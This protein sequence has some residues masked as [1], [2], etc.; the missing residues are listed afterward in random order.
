MTAILRN[1]AAVLPTGVGQAQLRGGGGGA[2]AARVRVG[3][4]GQKFRKPADPAAELLPAAEFL[5]HE[6]DFEAI[7]ESF[8]DSPFDP[9]RR[10]VLGR[11][12]GMFAMDY[13]GARPEERRFL[14]RLLAARNAR[15]G[16]VANR[17]LHLISTSPVVRRILSLGVAEARRR[18]GPLAGFL[19]A[20]Q[21]RH[22]AATLRLLGPETRELV[23]N[24]LTL[25]GGEAAKPTGA[26]RTLERALI[27]KA[28][29]ARRHALG[30]WSREGQRAVNDVVAFAAEI[31]GCS[32]PHLARTTTVFAD[33]IVGKIARSPTP[34][35]VARGELDPIFA[36]QL[37]GKKRDVAPPGESTE[38]DEPLPALDRNLMLDRTRLHQALAEARA[39]HA[40][41]L[42]Q[43]HGE[44]IADYIAGQRLTATELARKDEALRILLVKG[45]DVARIEAI[46][47]MRADSQG[48]YKFDAAR[49]LSDLL[50]HYTGAAYVRRVFSDQL[51]AGADPL[52]QIDRAVDQG[53]CVPVT[54]HEL[55]RARVTACAV[56]ERTGEGAAAGLELYAPFAEGPT[57]IARQTLLAPVLPEALGERVR[58]DAYLAPA[59]LD[60]LAPPF[61][62]P[63]VELGVEDRL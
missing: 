60:L 49:A 55:K 43:R 47:A 62:I 9:A 14:R 41:V 2:P 27:L 5:G 30:P 35:E 56:R 36:W 16:Y 11:L 48:L 6:T 44:A 58:A 63:F 13:Q 45:F 57:H 22:A 21:A 15:E 12:A 52:G 3:R 32:K 29:A 28:L 34:L 24:L 26:D 61:G 39:S 25:A 59:A 19:G 23:W 46:E 1:N 42:S 54:L 18:E 53:L 40:D 38:D 17:A 4:A 8:E 31:R 20:V 37:H 10:R 50:S 33:A 7:L 51:T